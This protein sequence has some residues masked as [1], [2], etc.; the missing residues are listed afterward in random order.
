MSNFPSVIATLTDPQPAD[1]LNSPSHSTLHQ[2]ENDEIEQT[3]R[4]IGLSTSSAMGTL[5]YDIRSSDSN[6]GGHV[7]TANKGGTGQTAFT[8]GD[9][10]VATSASVLSKLAVGANLGQALVV[11]P[12]AAAGVKWGV[13][14]IAPTVRVYNIAS[15]L[16]AWVK[17][18]NLAYIQV[19]VLGAGGS[20][21]GAANVSGGG[22]GSGG[23]ANGFI[24]ASLLGTREDIVIGAAVVGS[25][26]GLSRFGSILTCAGGGAGANPDAGVA[27]SVGGTYSSSV[28]S[29]QNMDGTAARTDAGPTPDLTAAGDGGDS[30]YGK[31]GQGATT[32]TAAASGN[33]V[34]GNATGYGSGG[35]GSVNTTAGT[36]TAGLV[37]VREY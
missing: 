8:K 28:F 35:G 9:L 16:V 3:Q 11:D 7:Q 17:P 22:G 31:G 24:P 32:A 34:G 26:G 27:G 14:G 36:A 12:T 10:L 5:V 1:K 18:S 23:Y 33:M 4:F 20:G 30:P 15:T 37:I 6:G 19:E 13:A 29:I 2:S 25:V 21:F